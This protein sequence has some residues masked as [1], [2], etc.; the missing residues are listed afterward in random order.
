M[1]EPDRFDIREPEDNAKRMV[2]INKG[3]DKTSE[4]KKCRDMQ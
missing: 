3:R 1:K 2:K 4:N